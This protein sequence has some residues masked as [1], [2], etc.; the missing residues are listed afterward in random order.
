MKVR[1]ITADKLREFAADLQKQKHAPASINRS[2]ACLRRMLK[3]AHADGK[4]NRVPSFTI[5]KEN[6]GARSSFR[7]PTAGRYSTPCRNT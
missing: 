7:T 1:S 5:P 2:L 3:L 4:L 6:T